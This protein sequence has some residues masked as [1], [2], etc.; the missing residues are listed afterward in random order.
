M[1]IFCLPALIVFAIFGIF[2]AKY[3]NLT[4]EAFMCVIN[5]STGRKCQAEFEQKVK[6]KLVGKLAKYSPKA[7]KFLFKHFQAFSFIFVALFLA[8]G[9][10]SIYGGINFYLYGNCDGLESDNFCMFDPTG[11]NIAGTTVDLGEDFETCSITLDGS[12]TLSLTEP[13]LFYIREGTGA[14]NYFFG[15]F[16][17]PYTQEA[18]PRIMQAIENHDTITTFIMVQTHRGE[19]MNDVFY[20]IEDERKQEYM[21]LIFAHIDELY[22]FST[23]TEYTDRLLELLEENNFNTE[24]LLKCRESDLTQELFEKH[25]ENFLDISIGATPIMYLVE[26][27]TAILGPRPQR[28]YTRMMG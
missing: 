11:S 21:N 17:C 23:H 3:R 5:K 24:E 12:S 28:V 25:E 15:S 27:D 26:S 10:Y 1:A 2:S 18:Y 16:T 8:S 20:C 22:D 6:G 14:E 13:G 4:K 9:V 7:S 19:L